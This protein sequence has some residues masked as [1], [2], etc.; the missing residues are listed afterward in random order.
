METVAGYPDT[1]KLYQIPA[2]K[3]WQVRAYMDGRIV[4]KSTKTQS[5]AEALKAAKDFYNNLLLKQSQNLP[6]TEGS[7][8]EQVVLKLMKEDQAR[9]ELNEVSDRLVSDEKYIFENDIIPFFR[10]TSLKDVTYSRIN[11]YVAHLKTRGKKPVGSNT[12]KNHFVFLRKALKH[13]FKLGLLDKMPMFPRI[14][15]KDNPR[16]WFTKEQYDL[17]KKT[18][19]EE[20]KKSTVVRYHKITD[21]LRY[22][23]T[24]MVNSWL[25]PSD[26]RIC[27][28][29]TLRL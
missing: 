19:A 22:L 12:I 8:F 28:I 14:K 9:A 6:L 1:L 20:I 29:S 11:D 24:F 15:A 27:R 2:S 21:E 13:A 18:I 25:R 23:T 7:S 10:K 4:K 3:Y 16:E 5:K 17:L 26:I